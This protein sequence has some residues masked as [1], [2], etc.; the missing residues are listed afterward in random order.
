MTAKVTEW[1]T[2]FPS[3]RAEGWGALGTGIPVS[4]SRGV[5][6]GVGVWG[7]GGVGRGWEA[8][9]GCCEGIACAV[10][11]EVLG[12]RRGVTLQDDFGGR[13]PEP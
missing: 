7:G 12:G 5:G 13:W 8:A 4:G 6:V 1:R 11:V 3:C 9:L 2:H 10:V